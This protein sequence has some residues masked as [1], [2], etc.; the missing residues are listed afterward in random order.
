MARHAS[1]T[2]RSA[3]LALLLIAAPGAAQEEP[4]TP[5]PAGS[6]SVCET[7]VIEHVFI[8]NHSIFD[9]SDPDLDSRFRWAYS[10]ANKLHVRTRESVIRREL[11]F[12]PGDCYDPLLLKESERILRAYPFISRTDVYG[13]Q[14]PNGAY[15]VVVDTEDEWST[16]VEVRA[17]LSGRFRLEGVDL[18]EQNFLGYGQ[19]V[20]VFYRSHEA[21]E[22]WG[23]RYFTPQLLGTRWDLGIAAGRTRT[24]TLVDQQIRYPFLGEVGRWGF[25]QTLTHH[26]RLFDYI[27]PRED[28]A[29][30]ADGPYCR[31]LLPLR[32]RAVQ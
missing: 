22:T 21:V 9:T 1:G 17:D 30:P 6:A 3:L 5:I 24:G 7:G 18:T 16:Q 28:G 29:C 27:L 11:L 31:V 4:G 14:Q 19:E 25:R 13:I 8:D 20:G 12:A 32:E 2:A 15:H 23:A 26:D 10:A